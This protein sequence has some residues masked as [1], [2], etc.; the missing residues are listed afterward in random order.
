LELLVAKRFAEAAG[1]GNARIR[2]LLPASRLESAWNEATDGAGGFVRFGDRHGAKKGRLDVV[3]LSCDFQKGT[4]IVTVE[5]DASA[6]VAHLWFGPLEAT[7]IAPPYADSRAISERDLEVGPA[8]KLAATLT[9]PK[10]ATR[11]PV[12]VLVHGSGPSDR[13]ESNGGNKIFKDIAWGL[14]SRGVAVLRYEKRT[15]EYPGSLPK[16]A[17]YEE[18]VER[19]ARAILRE[20]AALPEVDP[21]KVFVVG[22]SLGAALAPRIASGASGV[23]GVVLL[24]GPTRRVDDL[25]AYQIDYLGR[26]RGLSSRVIQASIQREMEIYEEARKPGPP[27]EEFVLLGA[28]LS[29]AYLVGEL[30]YDAARAAAELGLPMLVLQGSR[31]YQVT[32]AADFAGYRRALAGKPNVVMKLYPGLNHHLVFGTGPSVPDEY[33]KP[34]HVDAEL[35]SDVAN[36]ISRG[37]L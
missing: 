29:R 36:W 16:A 3:W 30:S 13:D 2:A 5:L 37:S 35:I 34:G 6:R 14:A 4:I 26:A 10:G 21:S 27:E 22:H 20:A 17:T 7:W 32:A 12:A 8:P 31:D 18:E 19:D 24:A 15:H 33:K 9:V 23:A 28:S 1:W 11:S 25:L